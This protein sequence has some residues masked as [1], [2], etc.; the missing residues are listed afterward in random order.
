MPKG[1]KNKNR[2][3]RRARA[4]TVTPYRETLDKMAGEYAALLADPCNAKLTTSV[5]PGANGAFV[6][7]FE[8]DYIIGNSAGA[9][10]AALVYTPGTNQV[11]NNSVEATTDTTGFNLTGVTAGPGASFLATTSLWRPIACCLEVYWPGTE[12]NRSGVI[13]LGLVDYGIVND[14]SAGLAATTAN[15]RSLCQH[16]ERMPTEKAT[17]NWR[18]GFEDGVGASGVTLAITGGRQ[19]ILLSVAGTPA[20]V[21]ARIRIVTVFEWWPKAGTGFVSQVPQVRTTATLNHVL[22]KLDAAGDWLFNT[23]K[24]SQPYINGIARAVNYGVKTLGPALIAAA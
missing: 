16:T 21:V 7:R 24:K 15:L 17:I 12:L 23:Y 19:S 14:F 3:S 8:T 4:R 6:G 2:A 10:G 11:L 22:A 9:T 20:S 5:F 18:P 1:N 13:G